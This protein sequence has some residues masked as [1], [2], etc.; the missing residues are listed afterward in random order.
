MRALLQVHR[1]RA[2]EAAERILS[3]CAAEASDFELDEA[4]RQSCDQLQ[5]LSALQ[6]ELSAALYSG[7]ATSEVHLISGASLE[8]LTNNAYL[9]LMNNPDATVQAMS[10]GPTG[11]DLLLAVRR[12]GKRP[13]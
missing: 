5:P 12:N 3:L 9:W 11:K 2:F 4:I 10:M 13:R 7:L 8:D 6:H 1:I